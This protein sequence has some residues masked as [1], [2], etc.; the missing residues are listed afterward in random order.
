LKILK[1]NMIFKVLALVLALMGYY[2]SPYGPDGTTGGAGQNPERKTP[3]ALS[4]SFYIAQVTKVA[5]GDTIT[6][7]NRDGAIHKIRLHAIDAPEMKQAGGEQARNWLNEQVM[8][9]EVKIVVNNTDRYQRQVANVVLPVAG[10]DQ[11]L[12]DGEVDVNLQ[13]IAA[14]QAWWYRDYSRGQ[15]SADRLLY[16]AAENE[17]RQGRKGLWRQKAP[18]A[19][20]QW[21]AEQRKQR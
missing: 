13:A 17:A 7:R 3:A 2:I 20:W 4:G 14:G 6:V 10:C 5:D 15:S 9:R 19:P 8:N 16:E 12:C 21:R 18:L 11:R 1:P